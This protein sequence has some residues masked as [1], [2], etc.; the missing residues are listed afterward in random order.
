MLDSFWRL[1]FC[2]HQ[3]SGIGPHAITSNA[4]KADSYTQTRELLDRQASC[5]VKGCK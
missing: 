3:R 5:E 2:L 4:M 1:R